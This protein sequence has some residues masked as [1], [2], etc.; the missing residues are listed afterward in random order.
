ML[1]SDCAGFAARI[2]GT[3][4]IGVSPYTFGVYGVVCRQLIT[5]LGDVEVESITRDEFAHWHE[6][7]G[8][9]EGISPHT[10]NTYRRTAR[11]IWGRLRDRGVNVCDISGITRMVPAP[12]GQGKAISEEHLQL[13]LNVANERDQAIVLFMLDS[14]IRRQSVPVITT[15]STLIY[16]GE[17]NR[18]RMVVKIPQEKTSAPRPVFAGHEAA[19]AV[20]RWLNT[21]HHRNSS[22][23]FNNMITGGRLNV[24]TVTGLFGILR[25]RAGLP[26]GV[27]VNAHALRHRF[28]Q[29]R[30][31]RF[32]AKIV[33]QWMGISVETVLEVY[34]HR[35]YDELERLYF[36][37]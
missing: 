6:W 18:L 19:A 33:A 2:Q 28:A 21:R 34:A 15:R 13:I 7:V 29:D 23:V 5:Y 9:R 27:G 24:R 35:S 26:A 25:G 37:I 14:G 11:A 3:T 10:I 17:D 32:D 20:Q 30:L 31:G 22:Y 16:N 8:G 12:V 1:L 36:S 4:V